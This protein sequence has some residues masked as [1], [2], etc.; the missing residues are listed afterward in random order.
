MI[1]LVVY[2]Q[3]L[4]LAFSAEPDFCK[5]ENIV[6]CLSVCANGFALVLSIFE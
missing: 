1:V 4:S 5:L 2:L 3:L 6:V